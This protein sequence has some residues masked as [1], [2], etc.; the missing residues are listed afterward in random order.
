MSEPDRRRKPGWPKLGPSAPRD[1]RGRPLS[2]AETMRLARRSATAHGFASPRQDEPP[3]PDDGNDEEEEEFVLPNPSDYPKNWLLDINGCP[4]NIYLGSSEADAWREQ[5]P[6]TGRQATIKFICY[7]QDRLYFVAG[8]LGTVNYLGGTIVRTDPFTLPVAAVDMESNDPSEQLLFAQAT[9]CTSIS[10]IEGIKWQTDVDGSDVTASPPLPGWGQYVFAIVTAQFTTP[11][12]SIDVPDITTGPEFDDLL[13]DYSYTSTKIRASGEAFT[14]PGVV[15]KFTN[16][17][18]MGQ[19]VGGQ[20]TVQIRSRIELA[21]TRLRM[22]L[23]P[24]QTLMGY[25]G[26]LNAGDFNVAG[27]TFPRGSM[28][29]NGFNPEPRCDPYNGGTIYDVELVFICNGPATTGPNPGGPPLDWN[30]F[31]ASDGMWYQ[32]QT[33][34]NST[35]FQYQDFSQLFSNTI[36]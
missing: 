31:M 20:G 9:Y 11:P 32:V 14:P 15:F 21:S 30:F 22:P 33:P 25:I 17:P 2:R 23:V 16:G 36:N 8:L 29:F 26:S 7:W 28:L 5:Y 34:D 19:P 12:Y 3:V 27:M 35:V 10:D 4:C 6:E 13:S 24:M 1:R 18:Q